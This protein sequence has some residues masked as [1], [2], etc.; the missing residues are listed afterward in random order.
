[1]HF[2]NYGL[3]NTW[4]NKCLKLPVSEDSSTSNIVRGPNIVEM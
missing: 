2:G 1:M 3:Q 4:L